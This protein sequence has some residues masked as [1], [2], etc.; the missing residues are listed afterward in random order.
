MAGNEESGSK[1]MSIS[2]LTRVRFTNLDK[3]MY[4]EVHITKKEVIM[5]YIRMAPRMLPFMSDRAVTMH[6]FPGGIGGEDFY[7]KDA[8]LGTPAFVNIFT[9]YSETAD[10]EVNFVVCNNLD[11]LIWLANLASLEIHITL[12][13]S[14]SYE[15]PDL[16][17]FDIDPEPPLGFDDVI[18]VSFI[19][20]EHLEDA[21]MLAYVKTSGKKGLHIVVPLHTGHRFGEVREFAHRIG[22]DIAK[23]TSHVVSEFPRSQDPGTIFVDY[24]QNARGKTMAAPYSLRGT[25]S[26]TVSMPL[27][28]DELKRGVRAEDFNIKTVISEKE[29]PWRGIFDNKQKIRK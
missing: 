12:S 24:L 21:G 9:H 1:E 8:P 18:D 4:P 14:R 28:W 13:K 2:D 11:T 6:R 19:V 16:I 20:R 15:S 3:I 29:E 27:R 25:P 23:D 26:A 17:L 5:Y 10:R 7:E 22:K